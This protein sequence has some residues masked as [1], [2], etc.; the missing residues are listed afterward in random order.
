M[1][2]INI[3]IAEYSSRDDSSDRSGFV[4]HDKILH[5]RSLSSKNM[6][7]SFEPEGIL[8]ISC[9]MRFWYIYC[10]EVEILSRHLHSIVDVKSHSDK[11]IFHF[12]LYKSDRM[13]ASLF[14]GKWNSYILLFCFESFC[15]E[16]FFDT[17]SFSLKCLSDNV[18]SFIRCF[19]NGPSFFRSEIFESLEDSGEFTRFTEDIIAI[20]NK[21]FF[22]GK[23]W[24]L[25][26]NLGL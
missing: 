16:I 26:E 15:D 17:F 23:I 8:H 3:F 7:R 21:C 22:I 2:G 14:T 11:S 1:S 18:T 20:G 19:S 9:W 13:K 24:E 10:I 25:R 4:F 12:S 6:T 5:T